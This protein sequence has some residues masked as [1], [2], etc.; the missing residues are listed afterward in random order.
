M[1]APVAQWLE[2]RPYKAGV[3]GSNPSRRTM[4]KPKKIIVQPESANSRLDVFLSTELKI[5]RSQVQKMIAHDQ[6][7]VNGKLPKKPAAR[8]KTG[9]VITCHPE[10][11]HRIAATS[12]RD[13]E[14]ASSLARLRMTI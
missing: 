9:S 6:I 12:H 1:L 3:D 7:L 10:Q 8:V 2:H 11:S 13:Q 5:S 14:I 4:T